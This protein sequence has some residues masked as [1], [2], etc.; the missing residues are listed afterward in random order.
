MVQ[1]IHEDL[2]DLVLL[3]YRLLLEFLFLQDHQVVQVVLVVQLNLVYLA[4]RLIQ[5]YLVHLVHLSDRVILHNL[6]LQF[7]LF[8]IFL[9]Y[10]C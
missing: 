8:K 5:V 9:L 2:E 7:D 4:N 3:F 6:C 10:N 1:V